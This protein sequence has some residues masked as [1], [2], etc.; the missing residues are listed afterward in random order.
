MKKQQ[1]PTEAQT[2]IIQK[3]GLDPTSVTVTTKSAALPMEITYHCEG[4]PLH[5]WIMTESGTLKLSDAKPNFS[6]KKPTDEA[7]EPQ[8]PKAIEFAG[9]R[10]NQDELEGGLRRE[11][12][13]DV[14]RAIVAQVCDGETIKEAAAKV[15]KSY[16]WAKRKPIQ[17]VVR[18]LRKGINRFTEPVE[19]IADAPKITS[20][21]CYDTCAGLAKQSVT[22]DEH[23]Y[24]ES[25]DWVIEVAGELYFLRK[26]NPDDEYP[27]TELFP[28]P[29]ALLAYVAQHPKSLTCDSFSIE[30]ATALA[31][32]IQTARNGNSDV[33]AGVKW[34][35]H[36]RK[37]KIR[38]A[39]Y[40]LEHFT[41]WP[42]GA[43]NVLA[44]FESKMAVGLFWRWLRALHWIGDA[45]NGKP[46]AS[47][48]ATLRAVHGE[49]LEHLSSYELRRLIQST[50][51][52]DAATLLCEKVTGIS[53]ETFRRSWNELPL[54]PLIE[55][56]LSP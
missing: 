43:G 3:A 10:Y 46:W 8:E 53:K 36:R 11:F 23:Y 55:G 37:D 44:Y 45:T 22:S 56:P 18:E 2:E 47:R 49:E 48:E 13:R 39:R 31:E 14:A 19:P 41:Q 17:R 33:A 15:G 25:C 42:K 1:K 29:I 24:M 27:R 12:T 28:S 34:A 5:Y 54:L 35:K 30:F 52:L 9:T 21:F 51:L 16:G 6:K 50:D 26:A 40:A 7:I 32:I 4:V 38:E 20:N